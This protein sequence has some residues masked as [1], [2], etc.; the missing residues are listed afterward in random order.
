MLRIVAGLGAAL[1]LVFA[2]KEMLNWGPDFVRKA[3]P[4]WMREADAPAHVAW[5]E[6]LAFNMG[7]YNFVLA[8]G[9]AWTAAS[10]VSMTSSL[11]IFFTVSLLIAVAAAA[12][13]GVWLAVVAQGGLALLLGVALIWM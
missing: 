6:K 4:T 5:S 1:H 9:L 12:Y 2:Y 13:T 7:A 3:A 10:D 8:I 11:G